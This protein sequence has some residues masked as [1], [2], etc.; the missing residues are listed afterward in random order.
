MPVK[1]L[2]VGKRNISELKEARHPAYMVMTTE[3]TFLA[4]FQPELA[5]RIR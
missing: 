2:C 1:G 3:F 4:Q 5:M